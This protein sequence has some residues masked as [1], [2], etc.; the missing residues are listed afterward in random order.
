MR[1]WI[2]GFS[3]SETSRE[4]IEMS[5]ALMLLIGAGSALAQDPELE[6]S[7]R[8]QS[9]MMYRLEEQRVGNWVR[10]ASL[11]AGI[12]R[13]ET[14]LNLQLKSRA[15]SARGRADFDFVL[16]GNPQPQGYDELTELMQLSR[17]ELTDRYRID[18]HSLYMERRDL[19]IAGLDLRA[20]QQLV[21][22]GVGDQFNPTNNLNSDDMEHP[23]K[24]GD[25]LGN[26]MV[27][28]DYGGP[29]GNWVLSGVLVPIF[30][31]ALLPPSGEL[32]L[33]NLAQIPFEEEQL[34]WGLH[35]ERDVAE[36]L[37][38]YPTVVGSVSPSLPETSLDNMQ[39]ALQFGG[40]IGMQ[41]LA[42]SYYKGR[43]DIPVAAANHSQLI[44]EERC[45]PDECECI[46]GLLQTDV[47]LAYPEMQVI[48]L[49]MAGEVNPLGWLHSSILPFGY[50]AEVAAIQT[51]RM[52][53]AITNEEMDFGIL[54]QEAGEYD[55]GLGE[56]VRPTTLSDEWFMKWVLGV[57][58][59]LG[60]LVYVNAQWVHGMPDEMGRGWAVRDGGVT[61]PIEDTLQ[62]APLLGDSDVVSGEECVEET[63]R[64]RVG[65]YAVVGVDI[66]LG[67]VLLR[68]FGIAD[69]GG[70]VVRSWSDE[71]GR[72]TETRY[73]WTDPEARSMV[74][75]PELIANL[76]SGVELS[77]GAMLMLGEPATRFGD[78][79][80]GG[81]QVFTRAKYS[82]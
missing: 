51:E 59:S 9:D 81:S 38:G 67:D 62:C 77:A 69:L 68:L 43:S 29:R 12:S 35:A 14:L 13:N 40:S 60:K 58:Y 53:M 50:R 20:G 2:L 8:I 30:Q 31:P 21:Q 26:V 79:A 22:W 57:D 47:T 70:L 23:L 16:L 54:V 66:R 46:D 10:D 36:Q 49:N 27:R 42:L 3:A 25:Q 18:V 74:L 41:D 5:G 76:G 65:D 11:P 61:T 15:G 75:Y 37:L 6:V 28:A 39:F 48:G 33:L 73:A 78:P 63:L 64:P 44:M 32:A 17:R 7:G 82:F 72:R 80:T 56:G 19:G 52:E 71:Q 34:R 1:A 24:F 4:E 55:Y 45:T